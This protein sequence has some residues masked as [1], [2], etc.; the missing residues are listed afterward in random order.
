MKKKTVGSVMVVAMLFAISLFF[1]GGTYAR[2]ASDFSGTASVGIAKWAVALKDGGTESLDLDLTVA[3]S[4]NV[5]EN[6]IA[7]GVTATGQVEL[8]LNGTEVAVEIEALKGDLTEKLTSLGFVTNPDD[9]TVDVKLEKNPKS[10]MN[11]Q[12]NVIALPN[13]EAFGENDTV[14]VKVEVKWIN[15]EETSHDEEHTTVGTDHSGEQLEVPITL[16][17]QQHIGE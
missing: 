9:I 4:E 10:Q 3:A 5:V 2:Y 17:V 14:T 12:E 8:N 1:I 16:K 15:A 7:P 11:I 6:K 13:N